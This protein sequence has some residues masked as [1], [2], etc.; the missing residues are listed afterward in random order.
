LAAAYYK[1][2]VPP[3]VVLRAQGLALVVFVR[4]RF[5]WLYPE[6]SPDHLRVMRRLSGFVVLLVTGY[7]L[8]VLQ[9]RDPS[10]TSH[11]RLLFS[12]PPSR[13][14]ERAHSPI[15]HLMNFLQAANRY[16]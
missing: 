9:A 2:R 14:R 8:V 11:P 12:D 10:Q 3:G 5:R 1:L 6:A 15:F 7:D 13:Q 4:K 16:Q